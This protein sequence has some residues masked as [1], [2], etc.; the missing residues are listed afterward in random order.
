MQKY[1]LDDKS[2]LAM[3]DT[4]RAAGL[5]ILIHTG[6]NRYSYSNP[7]QLAR[8]L[9]EIP[10]LQCIAAHFGGY[11]EWDDGAQFLSKYENVWIDTSSSLPLISDEHARKLIGSFDENRILFGTD[12]PM[13]SAAQELVRFHELKLPAALEEKI[14]WNNAQ[15]FIQ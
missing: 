12:Y 5:P 7:Q 13:W 6:D 2:A 4:V 3:F 15:R 11:T 14:L 9:S 8:V 10:G 1:A